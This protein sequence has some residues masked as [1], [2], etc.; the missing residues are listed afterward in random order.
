MDPLAPDYPYYTPY[1]YAGNKPITFIDLDGLEET[2]PEK[3]G[4]KPVTKPSDNPNHGPGFWETVSHIMRNLSETGPGAPRWLPFPGYEVHSEA[5]T[6]TEGLGAPFPIPITA[7]IERHNNTGDISIAEA[8]EIVERIARGSA[9]M[10]DFRKSATARRLLRNEH[11]GGFRN[12]NVALGLTGHGGLPAFAN[13]RN[14]ITYN[15]FGVT[16]RDFLRVVSEPSNSLH[17]DLTGIDYDRAFRQD[18]VGKPVGSGEIT[19]WELQEILSNQDLFDRTTFYDEKGKALSNDD[20]P[21]EIKEYR[22]AK[23]F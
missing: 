8:R 16:Q 5:E 9:T 20:L 12:T 4:S 18:L 15:D 7:S 14:A 17:F 10:D 6:S 3:P 21:E 22:K 19:S 23:G 2:L 11:S 1:Q 13:A